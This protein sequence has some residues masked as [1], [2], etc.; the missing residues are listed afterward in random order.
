MTKMIS[1]ILK[2]SSYCLFG[3]I[4]CL[5]LFVLTMR[6]LGEAPSIFGYSFYY[7]LTESM[8]P[9]IMAGDIILCESVD[10][11]E[12]KIGDVITYAGQ[13]GE[14]NGKIITHKI[15]D[16]DDGMFT[17]QGVA[18]NISDPPITSSQILSKYVLTIPL[19][20]KL[21]S[22]INSKYGFILIIIIPLGVLIVNEISIIVKTIKEDKEDKEDN[23]DKEEH[24]GE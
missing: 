14:L 1:K 21:F 16:I 24:L 5:S 3:L 20:G 22:L 17:T 11:E 4:I 8:E 19:A 15:V 9:E 6:F 7:V 2:V 18:N 13:T 10:T 12:L 23:K